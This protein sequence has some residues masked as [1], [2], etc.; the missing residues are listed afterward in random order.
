MSKKKK[1]EDQQK[2][3]IRESAVEEQA[4]PAEID[5][6]AEPSAEKI[7]DSW[8]SFIRKLKDFRLG[9]VFARLTCRQKI[10]IAVV[11]GVIL[12]LAL[13]GFILAWRIVWHPAS[14]FTMAP[15]A[16]ASPC[17]LYTRTAFAGTKRETE[18]ACPVGTWTRA[19]ETRRGWRGAFRL[20]SFSQ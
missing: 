15:S 5:I 16:T 4:A 13:T 2:P 20:P 1:K 14:L 12:L 6:P 11:A 7:G 9:A 18:T 10:T 17:S 8:R 3:E 19:K